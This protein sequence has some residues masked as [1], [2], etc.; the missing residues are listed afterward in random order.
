MRILIITD[1]FYPE[2]NA[3][4]SRVYERAR[5]WVQWGHQVTVITSAPN[6]PEGKVYPGYKNRWYQREDLDGI[7]V[8]RVKTFICANKGFALRIFDFLSFMVTA[9]TAA[10]FQTKMAVILTTSPQFFGAWAAAIV[11]KIKRVPL[12]LELGDIW[13]ASIVSVGA[14]RDSLVIRFLEKL[15]LAL[16]HCSTS[17]VVVSP[18][19]KENLSNRGVPAEKIHVILNGVELSQYQPQ[20]IDIALAQQYGIEPRDFVIG[21]IGT[22]G[23]AHN[24]SNVLEA[25]R[26]LDPKFSIKILFVGTGA[27][28][29]QLIQQAERLQL[30]NVLFV[31]VQPKEKVP[32]F[33]SLCQ[34][35]LV[36]FKNTPTFAEAIPSK[37]FEAMGMGLPVLLAAPKGAASELVLS[38]GVGMWVPPDE[39][40]ALA[41]AMQDLRCDVTKTQA[42]AQA[43]LAA[44]PR[45]SRE[46]QARLMLDAM[47]ALVPGVNP[48]IGA[49]DD[50]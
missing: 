13:P 27:E 4:A 29:A 42:L 3:I 43:S 1:N 10:L 38:E 40:Q 11:A 24:L 25:A 16:Y 6:F 44:A 34:V 18:A 5:H 50:A 28:R 23:M 41:A 48:M 33:W 14:M 37:I 45:H 36:H 2:G 39:P 31:S 30:S 32:V 22:H 7:D 26:L 47:A 9:F 49:Q 46:T 15:E 12:L 8:I 35:A 19:F 17:I 21:Y 20:A